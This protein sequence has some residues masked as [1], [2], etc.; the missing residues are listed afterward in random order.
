MADLPQMKLSFPSVSDIAGAVKDAVV[1]PIETNIN[2]ATKDLSNVVTSAVGGLN[3][4]LKTAE[5]AA[6]GMFSSVNAGLVQPIVNDATGVLDFTQKLFGQI[7]SAARGLAGQGLR[8]VHGDD[9][10]I[11]QFATDMQSASGLIQRIDHA[12]AKTTGLDLSRIHTFNQLAHAIDI[13]T[14]GADKSGAKIPI[15]FIAGAVGFIYGNLNVSDW[16]KR[17]EAEV[18]NLENLATELSDILNKKPNSDPGSVDK[19]VAEIKIAIWLVCCYLDAFAK[20]VRYLIK[21]LPADIS[22]GGFGDAVVAGVNAEVKLGSITA[23]VLDPLAATLEFVS[24]KLK[25]FPID[26][27]PK[28]FG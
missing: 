11:Q 5:N 21:T 3:D 27:I 1:S 24:E 10:Q 26:S 13:L 17:L 15:Q 2:A 25:Q 8:Y 9:A 7:D 23:A 16:L 12:I 20:L 18:G 4:R 6:S 14:G 19:L 28:I 22:V